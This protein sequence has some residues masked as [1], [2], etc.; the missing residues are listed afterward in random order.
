[1]GENYCCSYGGGAPCTKVGECVIFVPNANVL[2]SSL[3]PSSNLT[4]PRLSALGEYVLLLTN[5]TWVPGLAVAYSRTLET[6][7]HTFLLYPIFTETFEVE[8]SDF[9]DSS[10]ATVGAPGFSR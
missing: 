3:R 7:L 9:M 10:S 2:S 1:M 4:S 8:A 6:Y 5:V